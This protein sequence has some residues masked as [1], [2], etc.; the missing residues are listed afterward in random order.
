MNTKNLFLGLLAVG[1]MG[2]TSC[3]KDEINALNDDLARAEAEIAANA[4]NIA[5]NSAAIQARS[6]N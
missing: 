3:E 4:D 6:D 1:A 5:A 2:L